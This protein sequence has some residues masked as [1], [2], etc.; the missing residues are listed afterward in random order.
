MKGHINIENYYK[1]D[2]TIVNNQPHGN[3][4]FTYVNGHIYTGQCSFGQADG[5]GVYMFNHDTKYTGFFSHGKF[6]GI[7][8]VENSKSISKGTWRNERKHGYF[9]KTNKTLHRSWKQLWV[10]GVI[11]E[12][13]DIQYIQPA[14]LETTKN[15]PRNKKKIL[16]VVFNGQEHKC[17]G[18]HTQNINSAVVRCGHVC[19]CY[20]CLTKC[21][22]KCPI[23]RVPIDRIIKLYIS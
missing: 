6:H 8:T 9:L 7:G 15:N 4:C 17:I 20:E 3:G 10:K 2:G 22:N 14:A 12:E 21:D 19:M 1:Y 11:T 5:F 23:C 18:C 13:E 16:Q